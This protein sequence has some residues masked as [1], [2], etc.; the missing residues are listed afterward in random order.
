MKRLLFLFSAA[1]CC[2]ILSAQNIPLSDLEGL[3]DNKG[4]KYFEWSGYNIFITKI[5]TPKNE[6]DI[7]KIKKKY[8]IDASSK[9]YSSPYINISN[10]VIESV[11]DFEKGGKNYPDIKI[12]QLIYIIKTGEKESDLISFT[13]VG[14]RDEYIEKTFLD[15]YLN[16]KLSGYIVPKQIKFI[17]FVGRNIQLG[18]L[19]EWR[20][21]HNINCKGGQISWS[22]FDSPEKAADEIDLYIFKNEDA[23]SVIID[24]TD[25]PVI[26]E[27]EPVTARRI[28]YK[29]LNRMERYPLIVYYLWSEIEG[30]YVSCIMS[31]YGYNKDDYELPDLLNEFMQIEESPESAWNKYDYPEKEELSIEQKEELDNLQKENKFKH[32]WVNV[33]SGIYIPFGGQ[34]DFTGNSTYINVGFYFRGFSEVYPTYSEL[35]STIFMDFGFVIPSNKRQF[36]YYKGGEVW[37][38]KTNSF[39]NMSLG[40][41]RK[42]KIKSQL[43]WENHIKIGV[44]GLITNKKKLNDEDGN[45]DISVFSIG[46]GTNIRYKRMGIFLDYQFAPYSKSKHLKGGGNSAIMTGLNIIF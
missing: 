19:C 5:K 41:I 33:K 20:S 40:Y 42:T 27:G 7:S 9:Y 23:N 31:H 28:V 18:N 17:N 43:Y 34:R 32:Y 11:K 37:D 21:P 8:K 44:A 12:L 15:L 10:H 22:V 30:K 46:L 39:V 14:E 25:I 13:K 36:D 16:N 35:N 4:D 3:T 26:F 45:Y 2:L 38:V 24:D 1:C 6:K 29:I